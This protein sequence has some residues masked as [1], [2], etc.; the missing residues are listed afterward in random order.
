MTKKNPHNLTK[1]KN[2]HNLVP[3]HPGREG[4]AVQLHHRGE[5]HGQDGGGVRDLRL[6][7]GGGQQDQ[8]GPDARVRGEISA[9]F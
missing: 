9:F 3:S 6:H 2:P 1:K 8:L 5:E 7:D 4:A